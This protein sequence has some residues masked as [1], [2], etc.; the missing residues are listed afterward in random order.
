MDYFRPYEY[1]MSTSIATNVANGHFV[2]P[3]IAAMGASGEAVFSYQQQETVAIAG[4][5]YTFGATLNDAESVKLL[6]A[7]KVDGKGHALAVTLHTPDNLKEVL[8]A[9]IAR[10][11]DGEEDAEEKLAGDL[12]DGLLAAIGSD[13]L[14]NTVE[15]VDI[16]GVVVHIDAS[17]G[18]DDMASNLNEP[19][20]N[21]IYTQIPGARLSQSAYMDV[22]GEEK[23]TTALPLNKGDTLTFVFDVQVNEVEPTKSTTI[24]TGLNQGNDTTA[25]GAVSNVPGQYTSGLSFTMPSKRIAFNLKFTNGSGPFTVGGSAG[26]NAPPS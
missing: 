18:A 3:F 23:L 13:E 4:I 26:L 14:V 17:G 15:H 6:N 5:H 25:D 7:F 19:R 9:A 10:A 24:A 20:C 16:S 21:V 2:C 22:S 1:N 8:A 12:Y 11:N